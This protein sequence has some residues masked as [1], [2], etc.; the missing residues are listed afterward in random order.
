MRFTPA[1]SSVINLIASDIGRPI[2]HIASNFLHYDTLIPDVQSVLDTLIP[3]DQEL[4][5]KNGHWYSMH[6][7]PYR[8]LDNV[9]EGAVISFM[10]ITEK[11]KMQE[12]LRGA[13]EQ[14][15]RLAAVVRNS[16]DAIIVQDP[17]G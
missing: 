8:T 2:A 10:H 13:D 6:I 5:A 16:S 15:R 3:K 14:L 11:V 4:M 1:A 7:Q 12:K 17:S 9:I